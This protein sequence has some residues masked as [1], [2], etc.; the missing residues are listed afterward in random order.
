[1]A[2]I[3]QHAPLWCARR[4]GDQVQHGPVV[5]WKQREDWAGI[6]PVVAWCGGNGAAGVVLAS[7]ASV[8]FGDTMAEAVREL[9]GD[10]R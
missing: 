10:S 7:D 5:G 8:Y 2:M 4:A 1:M 3:P 6:E 9:Q